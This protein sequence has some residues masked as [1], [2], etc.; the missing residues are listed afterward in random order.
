MEVSLR[1]AKA[2][3]TLIQEQLNEE[4]PTE[5]PITK[6]DNGKE[7]IA[8]ETSKLNLAITKRFELTELLFS[9]RKKV[10]KKNSESGINDLLTDLAFNEARSNVAKSMSVI[11]AFRPKDETLDKALEVLYETKET[12]KDS[13][14]RLQKEVLVVSLLSE[15]TVN[16]YKTIVQNL[17]KEKIDI[18]DKLLNKNVSSTIELD[19]FDVDILKKYNII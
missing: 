10:S 16:I 12:P 7:R 17:R 15:D 19:K 2:L 13:Y 14:G 9:L 1:K 5:F 3:Q 8:E 11:K 4:V 6:F 18:N